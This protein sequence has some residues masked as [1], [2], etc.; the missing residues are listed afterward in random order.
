MSELAANFAP[1][2][3]ARLCGGHSFDGLLLEVAGLESL[4]LESAD[5]DSEEESLFPDEPASALSPPLLSDLPVDAPFL[6]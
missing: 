5:L 3:G 2:C 6:A 4:D 1:D